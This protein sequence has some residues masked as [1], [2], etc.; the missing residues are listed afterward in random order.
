MVQ[1]DADL[2][3][4]KCSTDTMDQPPPTRQAG[5]FQGPERHTATVPISLLQLAETPRLEGHNAEHVARLAEIDGPLPP[6]LVDRRNMQVIDG[7]HR[8]MAAVL[9]G[10]ATIE[11]EFFEGPPDD[12][13]LHAVKANVTHG[14]PLS[15][16]DRQQAAARI[17]RSHPHLSDRAIA[18]IAGLAGRTIARIRQRSEDEIPRP[19]VRVGRDGK[20][21]PI[22][23]GERRRRVAELLAQSPNASIR[24]VAREAGVSPATASDVRRRLERGDLPVTTSPRKARPTPRTASAAT[25][26][27]VEKLLRDP[28]LRHT[29]IGRALLGLL[30][31]SATESQRWSDL[32]DGVPPHC[33]GLVGQ[34]AEEYAQMWSQLAE[35]M[36]ERTLGTV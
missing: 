29:E 34:L 16:A 9:K 2:L 12:A 11:A 35:A 31:H 32:V 1:V 18:E 13:F 3:P 24:Q 15:Q 27:M 14:F 26:V 5:P 30:R 23:S 6:I 19:D 22:D 21:R 36:A 20:S 17:V 10:R 7:T 4:P 8:L 25:L 28:A 33:T